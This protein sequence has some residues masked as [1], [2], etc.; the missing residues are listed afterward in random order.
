MQMKTKNILPKKLRYQTGNNK[1]SFVISVSAL[2][3]IVAVAIVIVSVTAIN[4]RL[5]TARHVSFLHTS[6][7]RI[8]LEERLVSLYRSD[9]FFDLEVDGSVDI[10]HIITLTEKKSEHNKHGKTVYHGN[11]FDLSPTPFFVVKGEADE[12]NSSF[13][14]KD[15]KGTVI[16][17][18]HFSFLEEFEIQISTWID[19]DREYKDY[20]IEMYGI[21]SVDISWDGYKS[22]EVV[23]ETEK[24]RNKHIILDLEERKVDIKPDSNEL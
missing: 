1:G 21:N 13:V 6:L 23:V 22:R 4:S 9:E 17:D 2:A 19:G 8:S 5:S 7:E 3:L 16:L 10:G 14:I 18:K 15:T 20:T 24:G 12:I 11:K